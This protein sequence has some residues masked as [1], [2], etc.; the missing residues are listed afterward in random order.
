[1]AE[2]YI[3][4]KTLRQDVYSNQSA[5]IK[6]CQTIFLNGQCSMVISVS[7]SVSQYLKLMGTADSALCNAYSH[8]A[9]MAKASTS[10]TPAK[11]T[12][13]G[14]V[15]KST[16]IRL[17]YTVLQQCWNQLNTQKALL[18]THML[19]CSSLV[20]EL[21][22][23]QMKSST[24]Q[25]KILQ[26]AFGSVESALFSSAKSSAIAQLNS[27]KSALSKLSSGVLLVMNNLNKLINAF[28]AADSVVKK[29]I[30]DYQK[31]QAL[32]KAKTYTSSTSATVSGIKET[33]SELEAAQKEYEE[34]YG[35][36]SAEMDEEIVRLKN[37]LPEK[38]W[39]D[40][41]AKAVNDK[42]QGGEVGK[43]ASDYGFSSGGYGWC[44]A[45]V[46][47]ML[48]KAGLTE[49]ANKF[50]RGCVNQIKSLKEQNLWKSADSYTPKTG[51]LVYFDWP[52]QDGKADHVGIIYVE[53][54]KTY[55]LH[56]NWGNKVAKSD[57]NVHLGLNDGKTY[58][59]IGS[60][61]MGYGSIV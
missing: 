40:T 27:A 17:D 10:I 53:K 45:F 29:K 47:Y 30:A 54:G 56:G 32:S 26:S 12:V 35:E 2:I 14:T 51:D 61:I 20:R 18:Q 11:Y 57:I 13:S 5:I 22:N 59:T 55:I 16:T 39:C 9:A 1:M 44:D 58:G 46:I 6:T 36:R 37:L 28:K 21:T 52:P 19:R 7:G 42:N 3:K 60:Y 49:F 38:Q 23:A 31:S 8:A 43:A 4:I 15:K 33:I 41:I 24:T 25:S 50:P 34:A 48:K